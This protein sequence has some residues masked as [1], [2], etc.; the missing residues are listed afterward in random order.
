MC[1]VVNPLLVDW[2]EDWQH[3]PMCVGFES[4]M[5]ETPV[6]SVACVSV[7]GSDLQGHLW[8]DP[9]TPGEVLRCHTTLSLEFRCP[10]GNLWRVAGIS[11]M[12]LKRTGEFVCWTI[13]NFALWPNHPLVATNDDV[14]D[15]SVIHR[16]CLLLTLCHP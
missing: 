9:V 12:N 14:T 5:P 16:L 3:E 4:C 8:S 10:L 11:G 2:L 7:R 1:C 6:L 13:T 15:L